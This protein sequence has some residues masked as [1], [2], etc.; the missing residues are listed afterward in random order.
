MIL[1]LQIRLL[2]INSCNVQPRSPKQ[3]IA[4]SNVHIINIYRN[5]TVRAATLLRTP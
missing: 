1:Q 4:G 5:L 2:H 3:K